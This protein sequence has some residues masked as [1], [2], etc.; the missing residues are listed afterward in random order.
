MPFTGIVTEVSRV[1]SVDSAEELE[2]WD[3]SRGKGYSIVFEAKLALA[4]SSFEGCSINANGVC[5]TATSFD[6]SSFTVHVSNETLA[7]TNLG[8]LRPGDLVNL[9]WSARS[10]A[11]SGGHYV[12]G[13]VDGTAR[14]LSFTPDGTSLWVRFS[15]PKELLQYIV[16]K[17]YVA[18]D[19]ASLTV[20]EVNYEQLWFSVMVISST[21]RVI[22]LPTK[23]VG[24]RVNVEVDVMGKYAFA[25][26]EQLRRELRGT[27]Q[28][29]CWLQVVSA[30]TAS[31][32][33]F[34][35]WLLRPR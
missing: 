8:D 25:A 19:G 20:C 35:L 12:Q 3:G 30:A 21:Q 14:I 1:R 26:T 16:P 23:K 2:L 18:L 10:G 33:A 29:V 32:T 13:H 17:G 11:R 4:D 15:A 28:V 27:R 9:E 34:A 6:R 31:A 5:L 7:R 22:T 24:S